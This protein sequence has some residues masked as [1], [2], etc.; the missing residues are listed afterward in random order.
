MLEEIEFYG[1]K[2]QVKQAWLAMRG[3]LIRSIFCLQ[4]RPYGGVVNEPASFLTTVCRISR[5][6]QR[7][8]PCAGVAECTTRQ[9]I[10]IP[11]HFMKEIENAGFNFFSTNHLFYA[12]GDGYSVQIA[13]FLFPAMTRRGNIP[14][15][16]HMKR[17]RRRTMNTIRVYTEQNGRAFTYKSPRLCAHSY[18][19]T[20]S[21]VSN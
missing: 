7:T 21:L 16:C 5:D 8:E 2:V 18:Q 4:S 15:L 10:R 12:C 1:K 19:H 11:E 20:S 14:S 6:A 13:M 9:S 3:T 17:P